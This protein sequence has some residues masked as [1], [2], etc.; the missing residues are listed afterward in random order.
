[1]NC[2]VLLIDINE[3]SLQYCNIHGAIYFSSFYEVYFYKENDF[4]AYF[5]ILDYN[6][7]IKTSSL[8]N[9]VIRIIR[10]SN[11]NH[12]EMENFTI[13]ILY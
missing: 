5:H 9:N 6:L 1:M 2:K 12:K 8:F 13:F 7:M 10:N 3:V 11:K 4:V